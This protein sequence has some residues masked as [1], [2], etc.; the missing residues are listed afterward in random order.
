MSLFENLHISAKHVNN[1]P[2]LLLTGHFYGLTC[3]LSDVFEASFVFICCF[4]AFYRGN[5]KDKIKNG[6]HGKI[7]LLFGLTVDQ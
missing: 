7:I 2:N 5:V 1:T 4:G 6:S 3:C